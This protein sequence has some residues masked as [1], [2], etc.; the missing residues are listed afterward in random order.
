MN[1]FVTL[2]IFGREFKFKTESDD[3]KA[4]EI[5]EHFEKEVEKVEKLLQKNIP[6]VDQN[7]I[8]VLA[9][10]NITSEFYGF[11]QKY[12]TLIKD[13]GKRSATVIRDLDE[14]M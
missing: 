1:H 13:L 6:N 11:K 8:L 12:E 14:N 2:N 4:R 9:G 10:M 5:A 7:T 3:I